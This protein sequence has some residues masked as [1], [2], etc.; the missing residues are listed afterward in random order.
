LGN[1][2]HELDLFVKIKFT[3]ADIWIQ[4]R[5]LDP[6]ADFV[7]SIPVTWIKVHPALSLDF[8]IE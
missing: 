2:R 8:T 6:W 5:D 4:D 3:T 1:G 7:P